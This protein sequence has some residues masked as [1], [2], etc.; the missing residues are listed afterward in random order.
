MDRQDA[1]DQ[2]NEII[3]SIEPNALQ[4]REASP[5]PPSLGQGCGVLP[6]AEASERPPY[7]GE[8]ESFRHG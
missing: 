1:Q 2:V 5:R 8:W 3:L 4:G 6:T 7:P